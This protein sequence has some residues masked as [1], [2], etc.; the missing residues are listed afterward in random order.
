MKKLKLDLDEIQVVS[1][2]VE[3]TQGNGGTVNGHSGELSCG[4]TADTDLGCGGTSGQSDRGWSCHIC[5]PMPDDAN[6][7]YQVSDI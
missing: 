1:F 5:L 7:T 3:T 4:S 2:T 6:N